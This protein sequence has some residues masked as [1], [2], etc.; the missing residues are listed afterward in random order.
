[1]YK[2]L[3]VTATREYRATKEY[4]NGQEVYVLTFDNR[5]DAG[6]QPSGP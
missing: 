6:S 3:G 2:A 4:P 5:E 1:V